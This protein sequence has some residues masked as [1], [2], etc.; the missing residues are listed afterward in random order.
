[1]GYDREYVTG[2]IG[3]IGLLSVRFLLLAPPL[4]YVQYPKC[5]A[6]LH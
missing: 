1:M 2:H 3:E 4:G 6:N 5:T